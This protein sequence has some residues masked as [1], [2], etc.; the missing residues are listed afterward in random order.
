MLALRAIVARMTFRRS[1]PL[2]SLGTA[3]VLMTA[4]SASAGDADAPT[5]EPAEPSPPSAASPEPRNHGY[6]DGELS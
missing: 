1:F 5:G 2:G 4:L 6:P 3:A